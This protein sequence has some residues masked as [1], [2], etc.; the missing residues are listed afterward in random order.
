[1]YNVVR[2][3][4]IPLKLIMKNRQ[5]NIEYL[6][7][8]QER[9]ANNFARALLMPIPLVKDAVSKLSPLDE[10]PLKTLSEAFGVDELLMAFRLSE[11]GYEYGYK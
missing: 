10:T 3:G 2:C 5:T 7:I 8:Q 4:Y 11:L 1:M 6:R 9:E